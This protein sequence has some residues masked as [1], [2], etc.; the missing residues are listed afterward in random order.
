MKNKIG[1][2]TL[3]GLII[4]PI[5]GSG[6]IILPPLVHEAAGYWALPAWMIMVAVGF[7]FAF[8]FSS[9][10]I[11]CP[12]DAGVA[13]AIHMAFGK[14]TKL[15][16]SYYLLCAGL[17]G[18]A[19]ALSIVEKYVNK[20]G[21]NPSLFSAAL[22]LVCFFLL[23]MQITSIGRIAF[24]LS[25]VTSVILFAG[26]AVSLIGYRTIPPQPAEPFSMSVFGY[27][28]LLLF[29][30]IVGWEI[31]GSYSNE[32]RDPKRTFRRAAVFSAIIIAV[33]DIVVA[34]GVQ[35]IDPAK[36]G[37]AHVDV[38][39][40]IVPLFGRFSGF[41]MGFLT[42]ALCINTYLAFIGAITRLGSSLAAE[43]DLPYFFAKRNKNNA[44]A[45]LITVYI[46]V[47]LF[48]YL[49]M[50]FKIVNT[51]N[52]I[53]V[54]DTFFLANALTGILAAAKILHGT[55]TKAGAMALA[56]FFA[57]ILVYSGGYV[58]IAAAVIALIVLRLPS[59][60]YSPGLYR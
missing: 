53:A 9:L 11:L 23:L 7:F 8:I 17:F 50:A 24:I 5:L 35:F 45:R 49:L 60:A 15:L 18:P 32:V 34:A 22:V 4:G 46:C 6:I 43:G 12:G 48:M 56:I 28:L 41:I 55:A 10:T 25:I 1:W 37:M 27:A 51:E 54:A 39:S 33:I 16:A 13:N 30:I 57:A 42:L 26:G 14:R 29:W 58:L 36:V 21:V 31:M 20:F 38:S 52:L 19:A 59:K 47:H 40:L 3:S 2:L 44:P